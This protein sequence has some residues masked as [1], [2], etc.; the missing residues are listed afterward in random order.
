MFHHLYGPPS[1]PLSFNLAV[2]LLRRKIKRVSFDHQILR[3]I[4]LYYVV[5]HADP[6][7]CFFIFCTKKAHIEKFVLS[8]FCLLYVYACVALPVNVTLT[9]LRQE[10]VKHLLH[11]QNILHSRHAVCTTLRL[12]VM[13]AFGTQLAKSCT[14]V[15]QTHLFCI[16]NLIVNLHG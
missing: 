4:V 1:I 5:L 12:C 11:K 10:G 7:D 15:K 2:V 8:P 3:Y 9:C 13:R 6:S 16:D 14:Q